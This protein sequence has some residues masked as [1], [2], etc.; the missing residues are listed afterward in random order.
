MTNV[1]IICTKK[2]THTR[3]GVTVDGVA[4]A[5]RI[6]LT[7]PGGMGGK[8]ALR[9]LLRMDPD[10]SAFVSSGYSNDPV[11]ANYREYGFCGA[12]TKPY[13][14]TTLTAS[15]KRALEEKG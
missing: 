4:Y 3:D 13:N 6:D 15:V 2:G 9:E 14:A 8:E 1:G 7:V 10:V 5:V 12:I 11:M